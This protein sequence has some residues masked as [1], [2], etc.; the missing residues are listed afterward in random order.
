M[1][2]PGNCKIEKIPP[3]K[4]EYRFNMHAAELDVKG[5]RLV[6]TD[7]HR[8]VSLPVEISETDVSGS[9]PPD[10]IRAAHKAKKADTGE[11]IEC[12]ERRLVVHGIRQ[13]TEFARESQAFPNTAAAIPRPSSKA[14]RIGLNPKYLLEV[15]EAMNSGTGV[16]LVF[17]GELDPIL[18]KPILSC[19]GVDDAFGVLMPVRA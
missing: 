3:V 2:L 1:K 15:A 5:K 14:F 7:G 4:D 8:I 19:G 12:G 9:V 18:I 6:A 11:S 10:A 16:E 13:I 17:G